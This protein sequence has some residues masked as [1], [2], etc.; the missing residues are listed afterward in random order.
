MKK[1]S[2]TLLPVFTAALLCAQT[3]VNKPATTGRITLSNGQKIIVKT[4]LSVES[5]MG[6][7]MDI[8]N[9]TT[10][11]NILEVK[12]STGKNYTISNTLTRLKVNIDML[13]QPNSYDSDKK[14]DQDTDIGKNFADKLNKPADVV[15]DNITGI[16]AT[17]KKPGQKKDIDTADPTQGLVQM[18]GDNGD[19]AIVSGAFELIPA[20]KN[21][22]DTWSDSTIEKDL[23]VF[24]NYTLKAIT[25]SGAVLGLNT[26]MESVNTLEIQ[27]MQMDM[28][29]N[30]QSSSE[31]ITD[32]ATG[33]VKK[34]TTQATVTGSVQLMGQSIPVNAK[35]TTISTYNNL[36]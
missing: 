16:A 2:L 36:L 6:P 5:S 27:G 33:Q 26:T 23:K 1:I 30:T 10:S 18:F 24:R 19:D 4:T 34:K 25:D 17:V 12:N 14:E 21:I 15:I 31:V 11:E 20:G 22:G 13:G 32:I 35:A 8:T 7:G 29:S 9:N 28:N 3:P